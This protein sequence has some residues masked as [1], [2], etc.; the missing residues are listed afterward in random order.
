[1]KSKRILTYILTGA[2]CCAILAGLS[3][4][5]GKDGKRADPE[6]T[7]TP[8]QT[9][10]AEPEYV[11]VPEYVDIDGR[12]NGGFDNMID[13]NGRF[14]ASMYTKLGEREK[15]EGEEV[16]YEGQLD[17]Y[18]NKLYWLSLDGRLEE[19]S[20]YAPMPAPESGDGSSYLQ[21]M[22]ISPTVL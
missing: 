21:R 6:K 8:A 17:V 14:L 12:F 13:S 10:T 7:E 5:G 18:G 15:R 11:Y 22:M 4:C 1:M 3:G 20:G 16:T 19:I 2:L 9:E